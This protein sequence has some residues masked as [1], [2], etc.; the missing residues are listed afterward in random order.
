MALFGTGTS[1]AL[2]VAAAGFRRLELKT[3]AARR[4]VALLVLL[5][6]LWSLAARI[7]AI[8]GHSAH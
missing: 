4:M 2:S 8:G 5:A 6:G 3:H 1:P 7:G